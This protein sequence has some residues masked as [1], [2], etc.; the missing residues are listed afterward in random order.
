M[1]LA[2]LTVLLMFGT[3]IRAALPQFIAE[4]PTLLLL[5]R[6][7]GNQATGSGFI[8]ETTNKQFLITAKHVLF[9]I[10]STNKPLPLISTNLIIIGWRDGAQ[11]RFD[12][13]LDAYYKQNEVRISQTRDVAVLAL[14]TRIDGNRFG[15]DTRF[16][17]WT[18]GG[19]S[20]SY[21]TA[22]VRK[23]DAVSV[24]QDVFTFGYPTSVGT[25]QN[26]Q[27]DPLRPLARRGIVADKDT[28]RR[29]IILDVPVYGGNS[30]GPVIVMDEIAPQSY[31]FTVIGIIIE[32]VPFEDVWESKRFKGMSHVTWSNSGYSIVEPIESALELLW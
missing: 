7:D 25:E 16:T 9:D 3:C 29:Q 12:Y 20:R 13:N 17:K 30:G 1:K 19:L 2:F 28:G 15:F 14:G 8:Y 32:F 31:N 18:G 6:A 23:L 21:P 4:T 24:G 11:V 26:R 10:A 22:G 27:L 5:P